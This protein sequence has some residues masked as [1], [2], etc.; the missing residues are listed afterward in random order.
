M[1][2]K[3]FRCSLSRGI[4]ISFFLHAERKRKEKERTHVSCV[5]ERFKRVVQ[6]TNSLHR[7]RCNLEMVSEDAGIS[8]EGFRVLGQR[9]GCVQGL[10]LLNLCIPSL[11]NE[12]RVRRE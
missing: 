11:F 10:Y 1:L 4:A 5:D 2:S 3:L 7:S 9:G 8:Q 12:L 6:S